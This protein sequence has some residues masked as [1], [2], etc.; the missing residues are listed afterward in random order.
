[1]KISSFALVS[2]F[3]RTTLALVGTW[4]VLDVKLPESISDLTANLGPDGLIYIAGGCNASEGNVYNNATGFFDCLSITDSFVSFNPT[5]NKVVTLPPLPRPRYR[6]G[7]AVSNNRLWLIGGRTVATDVI[8]E[9]DVSVCVCVC[10]CTSYCY[11]IYGCNGI[12]QTPNL[13]VG[14]HV[15]FQVSHVFACLPPCLPLVFVV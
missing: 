15:F 5:T 8:M 1:M 7:A 4:T 14:G 2:L 11:L 6:H 3:A 12:P 13:G 10:V 9:I